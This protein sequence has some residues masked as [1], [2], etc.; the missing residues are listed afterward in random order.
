MNGTV[1]A[2]HLFSTVAVS[3]LALAAATVAS[4]ALTAATIAS[5]AA[6]APAPRDSTHK[7]SRQDTLR[8]R[9]RNDALE[10]VVVTSVRASTASP[11]AQYTLTRDAINTTFVGEDA[12]LFLARTP[13]MT[14]YSDAGGY[15][16]YSYLR[17][18]GILPAAALA[19]CLA[20]TPTPAPGIACAPPPARA[21]PACAVARGS[22]V[23]PAAA[24][25][26]RRWRSP[27]ETANGR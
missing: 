25:I 12:P 2:G 9:S 21:D 22:P 18:R 15:S 17:L 3:S 5:L 14:A 24:R 11:A 27:W 16:G 23:R 26:P 19:C 20:C 13:S 1:R 6:Q 7:R 8:T 4:P 10:A